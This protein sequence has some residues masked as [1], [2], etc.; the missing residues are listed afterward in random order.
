MKIKWN[1]E[2]AA[3]SQL[4]QISDVISD[5]GNYYNA[6]FTRLDGSK[7]TTHV[8]KSQVV[9]EIQIE[10]CG[11]CGHIGEPYDDGINWPSCGN[12]GGV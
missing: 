5:E 12:C 2:Y 3:G 4:T 8:H 9:S 6:T 10:P 11:Y 7:T 1:Y